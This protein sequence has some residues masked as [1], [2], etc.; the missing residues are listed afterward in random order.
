[1]YTKELFYSDFDILK[2][3]F[4][5][6]DFLVH[7]LRPTTIRKISCLRYWE[8]KFNQTFL[9]GALATFELANNQGKKNGAAL[10]SRSLVIG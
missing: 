2:Y 5:Q 8:E 10:Y 1:M 9:L 4:R 7:H 3:A 6:S